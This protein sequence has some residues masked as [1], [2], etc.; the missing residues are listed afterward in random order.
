M[1]GHDFNQ[2]IVGFVPDEIYG[3]QALLDGISQQAH[4]TLEPQNSRCS[5]QEG[6]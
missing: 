5:S 4:G 2:N 6:V 3:I 1:A